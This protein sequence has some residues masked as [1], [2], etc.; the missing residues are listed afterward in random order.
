[1]PHAFNPKFSIGERRRQKAKNL[2][3]RVPRWWEKDV[4]TRTGIL[5]CSSCKAL[6]YDKHWHTWSNA[7]V[8]LPPKIK[9][10][11]AVCPACLSKT[12][13]G[14][15]KD[16][17]Y[18]GEVIL[19]GL[20]DIE[21]KLEVIRTVK[22]IAERA[23]LRNPEAQIIKIEDQGRN[24][25]ITTTKNQ[26]AETIGKE[27]DSSHKGGELSIR[28]SEGNSPIRVFW[29]SKSKSEIVQE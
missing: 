5:S 3:I 25:R 26:L 2:E 1:M 12:A 8:V 18:E 10:S 9:V 21:L 16:S 29:T 13:K 22:N 24:V 7:S 11:E 20:A 28:F 17:G 6:Y 27:V 19:S 14:G 15:G 4:K 23:L